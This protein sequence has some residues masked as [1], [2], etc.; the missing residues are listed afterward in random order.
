MSKQA[1]TPCTILYS[2][3]YSSVAVEGADRLIPEGVAAAGGRRGLRRPG[4]GDGPLVLPARHPRRGRG[5]GDQGDRRARAHPA[6]GSG[7]AAGRPPGARGQPRARR[8]AGP[9]PRRRWWRRP[10]PSPITAEDAPQ[11]ELVPKAPAALAETA[12]EARRRADAAAGRAGPSW[13]PAVPADAD[14][15]PTILGDADVASRRRRRCAGGGRAAAA[16]PAGEPELRPCRAPR[17]PSARPAERPRPQAGGLAT[18]QWPRP[19]CRAD[20]G[21]GVRS[22]GGARGRRAPTTGSRL[23]QLGAF[24]NEA[25]ARKAWNQLV[26]AERRPARRRRASTSSAPPPTPGSSTGCGSRASP[27]PTR[28]GRC[29]SR[30]ARAAIACIPVTLQ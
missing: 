9:R 7:R 2:D 3:D 30:C 16:Q 17:R 28:R 27:T 14:P 24:D 11:G 13:S 4:G 26:G 21:G 18:R 22:G 23:V 1:S 15:A 10:A 25:M 19:R 5:P 20:P 6:R 12:G 29:A 8:R